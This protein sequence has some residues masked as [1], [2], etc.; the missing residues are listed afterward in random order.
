MNNRKRGNR[1]KNKT[2]KFDF[3]EMVNDLIAYVLACLQC[4]VMLHRL[5]LNFQPSCFLSTEAT[6]IYYHSPSFGIFKK[7]KARLLRH[8]K[9]EPQTDIEII[10][11]KVR[12]D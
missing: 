2:S 9:S 6:G 5:A 11:W 3:V 1:E 10:H 7:A 12:I 8:K 4:I